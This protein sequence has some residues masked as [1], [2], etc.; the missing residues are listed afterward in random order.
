MHRA[1]DIVKDALEVD[2]GELGALDERA[3]VVLGCLHHYEQILYL[4]IRYF[5]IRDEDFD[6]LGED[7]WQFIFLDRLRQELE[8]S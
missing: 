6:V 1:E 8:D 5:L 3:H 2:I 4:F 7:G